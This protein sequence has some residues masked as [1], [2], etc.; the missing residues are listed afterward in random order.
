MPEASPRADIQKT[1][2]NSDRDSLIDL[3]SHCNT[4]N[5]DHKDQKTKEITNQEQDTYST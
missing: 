4:R 3:K 2:P 5:A 1:S